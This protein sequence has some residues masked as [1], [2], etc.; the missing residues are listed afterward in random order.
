MHKE[1]PSGWQP[2]TIAAQ[3][4]GLIEPTTK[5]VVPPVHLATTYVRDPD[6]QYRAGYAYGRPDNATTR[7]AETVLAALEE[8]HA[9]ALFGS[10][11]AAATA[12]VLALPAP[13]HIVAS[14]VM[15]WAFRHWLAGE[16]P[17]LGHRVD[18][19]D[20]SDLAAMAAAIKP[21]TT[22]LVYIETP[23]NPLWTITDIAAV[24]AIAHAAGALLAVD[25]TVA[26]PVL[27][28]P[29]RLG[30]D[31]VMHSASKYLNGH[32]DVIAGAVV[33][34][35]PG[36]A[37]ER[38]KTVRTQLGAI[39]GPF[40]AWLLLRG[41]RTLDV[42]VKT[43]AA[44]ALTIATRLA[45]DARVSHVLYPGLAQHPGHAVAARQM[46]GGYGGMLSIRVKGGER[47]AIATAAQVRLWKRAT[48]LGGVE[49]LIE[50][51][52]SVEGPGSPCPPD[53][54]RLS[55][56]LEDPDDL[57]NDLAQA[58]DAAERAD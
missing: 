35:Q 18:F 23:G 9:A 52:A 57:M 29:L 28:R 15:Y 46:G 25:S 42:R 33:A 14:Q 2:R 26:T 7:H 12:I 3:A 43:Q 4:L 58:L 41:L 40:E 54:L 36:E 38:V 31:L 8:G 20:S 1:N 37:W 39:I 44:T 22:K 11:M 27:T 49:S 32:S 5:A 19:V 16:A 50:H 55:V 13:A 21:G 34:A 10:G 48:S 47:A 24:A 51:R 17:R 45:G 53:L 6:N 56:G 30:A